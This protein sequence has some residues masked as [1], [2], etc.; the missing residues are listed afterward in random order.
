MGVVHISLWHLGEVGSRGLMRTRDASVMS[1]VNLPAV[2]YPLRN[3]F[4]LADC[5]SHDD[6]GAVQRH[7]VRING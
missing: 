7:A 6:P 2:P 3:S 1:G 5:Q 4:L